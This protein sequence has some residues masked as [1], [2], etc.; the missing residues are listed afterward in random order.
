VEYNPFTKLAAYLPGNLSS[1][2]LQTVVFFSVLIILS[3]FL[4]A[5]I[6][7]LLLNPERRTAAV[8]RKTVRELAVALEQFQGIYDSAP[9]PYMMLDEKGIIFK[10]NKATLRFFGVVE[11]EID[12]KNLF[13]LYPA[14][15]KEHADALLRHYALG[16]PINREE[17]QVLSKDDHIKWAL[18]SVFEMKNI[19]SKKRTGLATIFDIT[20]QKQLDR[21]KTEFVSLASH[22]LRTP[23]ATMKWFAEMALSPDFG[24]LLPKQKEYLDKISAVN[25]EMIGLVDTLLNVSRIEI[26]TLPIELKPANIEELAGNILTELSSQIH[27]KDIHI[28]TAYNGLFEAVT[29]DVKLLRIVFQNLLSNAIKYT[30]Q[31]GTV[32]VTFS[33]A[34]GKKQIS[35]SDTGVGIP[36]ADQARIF[37]KLFRAGNVQNEQ[38]REYRFGPLSGKINHGEDGGKDTLR[39]GRR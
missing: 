12:G 21:A 33:E 20:E 35:V 32:T 19:D 1:S 23:L 27:K 9:I 4:L 15:E 17:I 10:S 8:E 13:S 25:E 11:E 26:G 6:M 36:K 38:R 24:P 5:W 3:A 22:Q 18:L 14:K 29:T 7:Y 28:V 16:M 34:S 39:L 2:E 37:E 30:P 31:G